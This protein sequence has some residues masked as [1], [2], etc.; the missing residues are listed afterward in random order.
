MIFD[1]KMNG[2]FTI[3]AQYVA[4]AHTIDPPYSIT[5][6]SVVSRYIVRVVF[7]L[8]SLNNIYIR[9]SDIGYE[10]LNVNCW[11]NIWTVAETEFGSKKGEFMLLVCVLYGLKLSGAD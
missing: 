2:Q 11:E 8:A 9:A 10:Y 1:I 6:Y 5:Y 4:G 3:K 7:T